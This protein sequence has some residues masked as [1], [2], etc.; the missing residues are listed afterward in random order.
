MANETA[1]GGG[2]LEELADVRRQL[3]A[4][5]ARLRSAAIEYA[6][7]PDGAAE[8]FRRYELAADAQQREELRDIYLGGLAAS[9]AEYLQRCAL[10]HDTAGDGPVEAIPVG[11]FTDPIARELIEARIMGSLRCGPSAVT[12]GQVQ[13]CLL[14]VSADGQTRQRL[15]LSHPAELGAMCDPL[16]Q[17]VIAA[18]NQ[19]TTARKTAEFLGPTVTAAIQSRRGA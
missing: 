10:N 18:L 7:T 2:V 9:T 8:M 19:P 1:A 5:R 14:K 6:A 15:K 4:A 16:S 17:V 13:V 11:D 12:S 3:A